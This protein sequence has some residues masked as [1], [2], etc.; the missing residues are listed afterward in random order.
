MNEPQNS[1]VTLYLSRFRSALPTI[2]LYS[3]QSLLIFALFGMDF[4]M[5]AACSTVIFQVR[6]SRVNTLSDCAVLSFGFLL[7][8]C[9]AYLAS[10]SLVMCIV[11]NL[12][13]PFTLV[14]GMSSQFSPKGH[15]GFAMA[16]V[17]LELIPLPSDMFHAQL[18]ASAL[19]AVTMSAALII[20]SRTTQLGAR[21]QLFGSL[22]RLSNA[23]DYLA[24][25]PADADISTLRQ[26]L[27]EAGQNF[28]R[29]GHSRAL[30]IYSE[31]R[32]KRVY[33]LIALLFQRS[34]YLLADDSWDEICS[35][36]QFKTVMR[37][38]SLIALRLRAAAETGDVDRLRTD[39]QKLL[40]ECD[41]PN[42]RL[43]IF[44]RSFLHMV[45][46]LCRSHNE[47]P[48]PRAARSR[49]SD[50]PKGFL[51]RCRPERYEFRF[52]VRLS[53]VLTFSCTVSYLWNFEHTYWFPLHAFLLLQPSYEE[54]AHRMITRPVGTAVGCVLVHIFYPFIDTTPEMFVFTLVMS[55][56][57]YVST[58]GTWPQ[59]MFAT[60]FALTLASMMIGKGEAIQLR[61]FYLAMAV[62][63]VLVANA[64]IFPNQRDKQFIRNMHELFRLQSVYW[65]V[66]RRS[67]HEP[68]DAGLFSELLSE[69]HMV[70]HEAVLY[71]RDVPEGAS[72][73]AI[74]LTL[75]KM[76]SEIEQ[77]ECLI[78]MNAVPPEKYGD[79]DTVAA[80][81]QELIY[82]P[83]PS[84]N[85]IDTSSFGQGDISYVL[86]HY[87][88][89]ARKLTGEAVH[90]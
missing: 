10:H 50:I 42:S 29:M 6:N 18:L 4:I 14:I 59:A 51:R 75:W 39:S 74:L 26:E 2:V 72:T 77:T 32:Q 48:K 56:F 38:L 9:L 8:C 16:F 36:P 54:S 85:V 71:I 24:D 68:V 22:V 44:Y 46:L 20:R 23:F 58:P 53:A 78:Q 5:V 34:S 40:S 83:R 15:F 47:M 12:I 65:G 86:E 73:R 57:M 90:A 33:H 81:L 28:H 7:M 19:C 25:A 63:L 52:A 1:R 80:S 87:L 61:L 31:D 69:F 79:L 30:F 41:L 17:F 55:A 3:V 43:R 70:Y 60:T 67:L 37:T 82:P 13:V 21:K 66:I 88:A 27:Y 76:F 84:L 49:L 11:L 45:V 62:A 35:I 64:V 89:N